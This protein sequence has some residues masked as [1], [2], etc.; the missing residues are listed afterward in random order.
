MDAEE[1]AVTV[2]RAHGEKCERCWN[3]STRVGESS[4]YPTVCE[5]C[6]AAL[7]EIEAN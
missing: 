2:A 6:I 1:I 4:K 3:Y 5:R 7:Q